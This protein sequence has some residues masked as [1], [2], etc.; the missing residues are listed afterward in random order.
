MIKILKQ[1]RV[2]FGVLEEE[3]CSGHHSRRQGEEMQFQKL[4]NENMSALVEN[5]VKKMISPCPH[6]LHTFRQEYPAFKND[7]AVDAVHHSEFITALI[8]SGKIQ[9]Q[10]RPDH[11]QSL[12]YHDPCYLGRYEKVYEA[13]RRVIE[14]AGYKMTELPRHGE[15]SFCC[16]GGSAGFAREQK[17]AT[18][19]DQ[20]RKEEVA[21]SGAK[22]LVTACP[23]CKMMLNA[24]VDETKDLAELVAESMTVDRL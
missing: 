20:T 7:F 5:G 22:I 15:R 21:A 16:G 3:S 9:L 18:R 14:R 17:A 4:A 8:A 23:E 19:V 24:A 11:N 13:P 2:S 12:T 10:S 1:G 6:C